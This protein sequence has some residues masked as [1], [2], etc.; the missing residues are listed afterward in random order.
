MNQLSPENSSSQSFWAK[1]STIILVAI[2]AAIVAS[3]LTFWLMWSYFFPKQF[4]PVELNAR[5]QQVLSA[6]IDRLDSP[7]NSSQNNLPEPNS[8]VLKPEKY[9]EQDA[10]REIRFTERELNALLANNTDLA[11]KLAIDLTEDSVSAKLLFALDPDFPVL[12]GKTLRASAGM[13]LSFSENRPVVILQG[14]SVWGVPM[15]SAWMGGLKN[16]DLVHEFGD[17]GGFWQSLAA[18]VEYV[19][20]VDG[21]LQ[22]KL[23][24]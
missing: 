1:R 15:P 2:L 19:R 13:E 14:F 10:T 22:I 8:A 20:V 9:T 12:G 23:K 21:E 4:K 16:V 18:G 17:S 3:A 7:L 5:E 24:E 6:K 11:Q